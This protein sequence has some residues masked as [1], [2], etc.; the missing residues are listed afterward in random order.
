MVDRC[1]RSYV[2][3]ATAKDGRIFESAS[4]QHIHRSENG[5]TR[6]R[7]AGYNTTLGH[8]LKAAAVDG[9]V[10]LDGAKHIEGARDVD[11]ACR[12]AG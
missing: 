9:H 4:R 6:P 11:H 3:A 5:R 7:N 8:N 10:A 1:A 12:T 2:E